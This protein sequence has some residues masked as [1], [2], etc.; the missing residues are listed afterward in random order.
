MLPTAD[1]LL[2]LARQLSLTWW[3]RPFTGGIRW[4]SRL[5]SS[6]GLFRPASQTIEVSPR[7]ASHYGLAF[8]QE[9]ILHELIHYHFP[10]AGHGPVFRREAARVG[11]ARHCPALPGARLVHVYV[12]QQCGAV[13]HRRRRFDVSKYRCAR[14]QGIIRWTQSVRQS[15]TD[16]G[17]ATRP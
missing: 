14:C 6:A 8:L 3:Q 2:L 17:Q 1:E 10:Q 5:R 4:N 15:T 7:Y 9:T 13:F 11:C 16:S 12:C